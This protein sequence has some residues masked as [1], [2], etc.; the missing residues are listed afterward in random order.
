M[1]LDRPS[2]REDKMSDIEQAIDYLK[3]PIGKYD[4]HDKAVDLAV[5]ALEKQIPKKPIRSPWS[6]SKCPSCNAELGEQ[7]EDGYC[8]DWEN[9]KICECGQKLDWSVDE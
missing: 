4:I 8:K 9:T 2:K 3:D 6:I 1:L 5:K 7:L